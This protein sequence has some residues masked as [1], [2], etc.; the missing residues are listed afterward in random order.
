MSSAHSIFE[1]YCCGEHSNLLFEKLNLTVLGLLA[2]PGNDLLLPPITFRAFF[3]EVPGITEAI[4]ENPVGAKIVDVGGVS[5]IVRV[6]VSS[7]VV[8]NVL[9]VVAVLNT[10]DVLLYVSVT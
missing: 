4:G 2:G 8:T 9:K 6:S 1:G 5:V 10:V 7:T 3:L